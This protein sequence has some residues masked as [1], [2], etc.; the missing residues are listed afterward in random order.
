MVAVGPGRRRLPWLPAH[1]DFLGEFDEVAGV[2]EA[3]FELGCARIDESVV[4]GVLGIDQ[5]AQLTCRLFAAGA[6]CSSSS[7]ASW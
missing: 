7:S 5:L 3:A 2:A 4:G 1:E 6:I